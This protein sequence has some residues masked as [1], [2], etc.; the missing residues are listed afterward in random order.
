[1][2]LERFF[3]PKHVAV[4]GASTDRTKIAGRVLVN[5]QHTRNPPLISPVNPKYD[6]IAGVRCYPDLASIP[7]DVDVAIIVVPAE[8]TLPI[9][10]QAGERGI[11]FV[12]LLSGGFAESGTAGIALQADVMAVARRYGIRVYG[13]NTNGFFDIAA[14]FGYTFSAKFNPEQFVAGDIGLVVQGGGMGRAVL[15]AMDYGVGFSVF[16][17][18]GNEA[19]LDVSDFIDELVDDPGTR[20]IA[21]IIESFANA[22]RFINAAKR[23]LAA[24]KPLV[25]LKVG[26]NELGN[27]SAQS[28]TGKIAGDFAMYLGIFAQYGVTLVDD[29]PQLMATAWAF[30]NLPCRSGLRIGLF[31]Y[32][33]GTAVLGADACGEFG[34]VLPPLSPHSV[35]RMHAF[36]PAFALI[37]NP[38][39]LTTIVIDRPPLFGEAVRIFAS[40]PAFDIV[41]AVVVIPTLGES[42][43]QVAEQFVAAAKESTKPILP[44]WLSLGR[45]ER[46]FEV[47]AE[48]GIVFTE[49][50]GTFAAIGAVDRYARF[51]ERLA[52]ERTPVDAGSLAPF[53][54]DL[55]HGRAGTLSEHETKEALRPYGIRFTREERANSVAQA[56]AS[57]AAIGYPVALK[58]DAAAMPHKSE[59]NAIRLQLA[60][61]A[62]VDAAFTELSA[63][64]RRE[65]GNA[66]FGI[67]VQEMIAGDIE[68]VVGARRDPVFG[69]MVMAGLGGIFVE[70]L[71]DI[72]LRHAPLTMGD[73]RRMLDSLRAAPIMH[74]V[75]GR[76]GIDIDAIADLICCVGRVM[77][78]NPE[79]VEL[80]LNPVFAF[81]PGAGYCA[82]DALIALETPE[83]VLIS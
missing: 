79:I 33:G 21:A 23:A 51:Q 38:A 82:A 47:L 40:D 75:R 32:S 59:S 53:T 30:S 41:V 63:I 54:A 46:S 34:L 48:N 49:I 31:T 78:D 27:R 68:L 81:P 19:D 66:R 71:R 39:D 10:T 11:P 1:M 13:P 17:S 29:L 64:A 50:R 18:T 5:L 12:V 2:S 20:V 28:H 22:E 62:A 80:D 55:P 67:L 69:P 9:M 3:H 26:R 43:V 70:A 24:G 65:L 7:G 42:T 37:E 76:P 15:D 73:A 4:V 72:Q 60:D 6:D 83:A 58:V 52:A 45:R 14:G 74:G 57:A 8:H 25:I 36:F 35:A 16:V 56:R 44:L 77:A 61:E